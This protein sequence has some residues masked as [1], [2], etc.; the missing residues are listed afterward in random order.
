MPPV[1]RLD[2]V[3]LAFGS[4]PLLSHAGLQVEPGE[5]V[6]VVGRNGEG[7]SSTLRLACRQLLPD[8]G[9]VWLRPGARV[10]MLE[11]DIV[12]VAAASV[13]DVVEAGLLQQAQ[14]LEDWEIPTRVEIVLSQLGLDGDAAYE[15]LSG[16]W[17]RRTLL[18]RALVIEPDLLLLDEPTNHLDIAAIDWLEGFLKSWSGALVFVTHDRRFLRALATRIVEIERGK[19][20]SWPGDW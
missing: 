6:C 13:R 20:T 2:D 14:G 17:R 12:T 7:K 9:A 11:Q 3:S 4:R 5:R 10:A 18:A 8:S 16:G 15:S 1:L 19:V